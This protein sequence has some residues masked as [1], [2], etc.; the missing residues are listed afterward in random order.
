MNSFIVCPV[1][2]HAVSW[3]NDFISWLLWCLKLFYFEDKV[4]WRGRE[5]ASSF[6]WNILGT[7]LIISKKKCRKRSYI[8]DK[9]LSNF[10]EK[11]LHKLRFLNIFNCAEIFSR[12]YQ[13]WSKNCLV[14]KFTK[15]ICLRHP[16]ATYYRNIRTRDVKAQSAQG[17]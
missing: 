10:F 8:V 15:R 1:D 17:H 14:R 2:A 5:E 7:I 9:L 16:S 3:N 4:L 13:N 12:D 6:T 11:E